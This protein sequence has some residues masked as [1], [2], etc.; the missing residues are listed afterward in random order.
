[1]SSGAPLL[2]GRATR[3]PGRRSRLRRP[4]ARAAQPR[5]AAP[6]AHHAGLAHPAGR[7]GAVHAVRPVHAP[8]PAA[9][10]RQRVLRRA[11]STPGRRATARGLGEPDV[12]AYA[13]EPKIDGFAVS[14]TYA[15]GRL[16]SAATRGDG[17]VGEDVTAT[18]S[19]IEADP[20]PPGRGRPAGARRGARR[21][22]HAAGRLRPAQRAP[23]R[24]RRARPFVNPRN[25]AAGSVRQKD[26]SVTAGRELGALDLPAR[27]HRGRAAVDQPPRDPRVA[28]RRRPPGQPRGPG[29]STTS[30][31]VRARVRRGRGHAPRRS[32]T[33]STASSSRSTTSASAASSA[34]R[35]G[36]PAGRS[37]T[38]SR[39]RSAPP[40][41][42]TSWC[43]SGAPAGPRPSPCSS[44][45]SSA[46]SPSARPRC[47]TRT[48][49]AAKDVRP[50][51]TVVVRRAGDVIPEVVGP[52]L[53]ERPPR[54][55]QVG[56]PVRRARR[57]AR[58]W[59]S[60]TARPTRSASTSAARPAPSA[61][62]STSLS[63]GAMDI[64]GLGE[65]RV[66]EFAALGLLHDIGDV[67]SL[68]WD[69]IGALEGLRRGVGAQPAHR[70]RRLPVPPAG[71]AAGGPQHPPPRAH[72]RPGPG[73]GLR[74]PR[75]HHGA[76]RSTRS[77]PSRASAP[78]S[79]RRCGPGSTTTPTGP[80]SR[81]CA[82]RGSTS[83][84][85]R[86]PPRRR[87]W[88]ACP[89]WSPARSRASAASRPRRPSPSGAASHRAASRRRPP[90][91]WWAR[92][93][94]QAKVTKAE[95]LGIP[96]LDQAAFEH[97]LETGELP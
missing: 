68:D 97:L 40:S 52:V 93:P 14:L 42:S 59:C 70:H 66:Q 4:G 30:T 65:Q 94:G 25:A 75:R 2:V 15:D 7:V 90:P 62:S 24:G 60:S 91:S 32:T 88:P 63:R 67:F 39:P 22:L 26:P 89:W 48:R 19:V 58:R 61:P 12:I 87:C 44:R 27:R 5:G 78:P 54:P 72:R 74:R 50:G 80:S 43:R 81:S 16:V 47:T 46:G 56:V 8:P 38:S 84:R 96:V 1:M 17:R 9:Q 18:V 28:R 10:P 83:A 77:R 45:C 41:C 53:A 36:R 57:A 11:S 49:S 73:P 23:G 71:Q 92:R 20:Q 21:D 95:E 29:A 85:S 31:A 6:R 79:R 64:E 33:R 51:D 86:R 82:P 76:P 55:A 3:A 69:R 37:P 35:R 34:A 13:C